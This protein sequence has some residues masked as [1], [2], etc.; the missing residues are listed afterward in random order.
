MNKYIYFI[1]L[2]FVMFL[3]AGCAHR[4]DLPIS[5]SMV[6]EETENV[7]Y[8]GRGDIQ[9]SHFFD[10]SLSNPIFGKLIGYNNYT[11]D[12]EC[13]INSCLPTNF[14]ENFAIYNDNVFV[15]SDEYTNWFKINENDS[16]VKEIRGY[17]S[18]VTDKYIFAHRDT[19]LFAYDHRLE[20]RK[21]VKQY[22][23]SVGRVYYKDAL[24]IS[25]AEQIDGQY[26]FFISQVNPDTGEEIWR[27]Q[28]NDMLKKWKFFDI[29]AIYDDILYYGISEYVFGAFDLKTKQIKYHRIYSD[30]S[31]PNYTAMGVQR[32][33]RVGYLDTKNNMLLFSSDEIS[34]VSLE[35][36]DV[37]W[38]YPLRELY[39]DT[40]IEAL[41]DGII[42]FTAT[43]SHPLL[44]ALDSRDSSELWRY[45]LQGEFEFGS[46]IVTR[47]VIIFGRTDGSVVTALDR[48]TGKLV[49]QVDIGED[50]SFGGY[51]ELFCFDD[52]L[53]VRDKKIYIFE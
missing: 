44:V 31:D 4:A 3:F 49:W 32:L 1:L 34:A 50:I 43:D 16:N 52:K 14:V 48:K 38:V 17:G 15:L 30:Q 19:G 41:Y 46:P 9:T 12:E 27:Y 21:W 10:C 42:Y 13:I 22:D 36:G 24:M 26:K 25:Y 29:N 37:R 20:E 7:K 5:S 23:G 53:V 35:N 51:N 39:P 11:T 40:K 33:G 28:V 6:Q 8:V 47:D 18:I 2:V 45:E